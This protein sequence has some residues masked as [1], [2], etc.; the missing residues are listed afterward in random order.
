MPD[1]DLE[2]VNG[3]TVLGGPTPRL[4]DVDPVLGER[5]RDGSQQA[6]AIRAGNLDRHRAH[7]LR[8]VVPAD[9]DPAQGIEV[10]RLAALAGV[11]DDAVTAADE[12]DDRVARDRR[13]ALGELDQDIGLPLDL[14][15]ADRTFEDWAAG[16]GRHLRG[17][18]SRY[19]AVD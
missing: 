6:W 9:V 4:R 19:G 13:A 5:L 3:A 2:G 18:C 11:D 8:F 17:G 7:R 10:E 14:D 12:P 15:A 1:R 16:G